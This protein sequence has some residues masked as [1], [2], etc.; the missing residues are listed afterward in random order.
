MGK[1][2]WRKIEKAVKSV[3]HVVTAPQRATAKAVASFVPK[4]EKKIRKAV[5]AGVTTALVVSGL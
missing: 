3:V 2:F 5:K 4:R 1:K